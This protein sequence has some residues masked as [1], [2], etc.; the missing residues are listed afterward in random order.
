M[1]DG[2]GGSADDGAS[3]EKLTVDVESAAEDLAGE[4]GWN[5]RGETEG[6]V[7]AGA[8]VDTGAQG[9][10]RVDRVERGEGGADLAR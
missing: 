1:V 3:G 5:G 6:F 7:D 9:G 10:A 4:V 2:P 8:Q